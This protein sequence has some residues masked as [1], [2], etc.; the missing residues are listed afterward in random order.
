LISLIL[1]FALLC[2]PAVNAATGDRSVK[3]PASQVD[4]VFDVAN[5]QYKAGNFEDAIKLYEGLLVGENLKK[6][7][8]YYNLGNSYF[9]LHKY[10]MAI[11][12]YRRALQLAPRDQDV[13]ANLRRVLEM[14]T[15]KIDQPKSTELM[16]E[17]FFF[18]Y[19]INDAEA[20][21][22]F[23]CSYLFAA[24]MGSVYLFKKAKTLRALVLAGLVLTL[25]FGASLTARW[26]RKGHP[27]AAVVVAKEVDVHTGPGDNYLISFNLHDGTE[28][29]TRKATDNWYQIELPDGRRGWVRHSDLDMI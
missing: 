15:D 26:Y 10:G 14:T 22:I 21:T 5:E 7:D 9:K 8:I 27:S 2:S 12:S 23:L 13:R 29:K 20:E 28:L 24:V 4:D 3:V 25:V 18:H 17:L 16:N 1:A 19:S 11:V 6:T